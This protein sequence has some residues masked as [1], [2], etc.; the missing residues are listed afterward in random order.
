HGSG[1]SIAEH[2]T[3]TGGSTD[4]V[5]ALCALLGFR[6]CPRLRDFP[7]RRLASIEPAARYPALKPIMGKRVRVELIREHWG[8]IIRLVAALK[9]GVV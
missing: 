3:D 7:D 8:D 1:L 2:Y 5:H 9:A 6:F 4:H